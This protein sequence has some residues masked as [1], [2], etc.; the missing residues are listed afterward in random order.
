MASTSWNILPTEMKLAVI[1]NLELDDVKA[2]SQV[3]QSSYA[4]CVPSIFK[5]SC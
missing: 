1:E 5:V 4:A 2:F 3:D